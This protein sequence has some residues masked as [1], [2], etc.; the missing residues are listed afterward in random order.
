MRSQIA[1]RHPVATAA[2][3]ALL[4]FLLAMGI[5]LGGK[6]LVPPQAFGTVKL[7][8]FASTILLPMLL[9]HAFGLWREVGLEPGRIRPDPVFLACLLLVPMYLSIGVRPA[10]AG[11]I[12]G[13]VLV[14]FLNAF[15]EELLFRGVIFALLLRLPV[16]QAIV[17]NGLLFGSMHL[18]HGFMGA[19][20]ADA[21]WQAVLTSLG[22]MMFTVVRLRTGS[23]WLAIALHMLKNL[24]V[25]YSDAHAA[26]PW[27]MLLLQA[28]TVVVELAVVGYAVAAARREAR[29][30]ATPRPVAS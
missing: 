21:A 6:S 2:C 10:A 5:L 29:A 19:G 14:Q 4:Q 15:G 27:V 25:M 13:D 23:L 17:L 16:L 7:V 18:L 30:T 3:C 22:G 12:G 26:S 9:V 20:W 8:A 1:T 28:V 24:A 11:S